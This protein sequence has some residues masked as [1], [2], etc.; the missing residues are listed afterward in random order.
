MN[1]EHSSSSVTIDVQIVYSNKRENNSE[2]NDEMGKVSANRT[3]E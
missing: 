1:I 3:N 2:E